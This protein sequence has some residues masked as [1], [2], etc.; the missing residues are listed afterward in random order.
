M[1]MQEQHGRAGLEQNITAVAAGQTAPPALCID[2]LGFSYSGCEPAL[3]D[4][5]L[6]MREGEFLAILGPNGGGKTTL[7]RLI[8]GLLRP[9]LGSVRVFGQTP[10]QVS[11]N[12]G[13]VPQFS[14]LRPDFP[15]SV[16]EMV[17]MGAASPS[18]FGG[19][20]SRSDKAKERAMEYLDVLGLDDCA[21]KRVGTLS[22]GQRQRALVARALMSRPE[23]QNG[24]PSPFLLLLDE[25]TASIDPQGKFCFYEFLGKLRGSITMLVISHDLFMVSP[26]FSSIAF[27]NKQLT[28]FED[29]SLSPENLTLL[30]GQHLHNCPVADMQHARGLLHES[31]CSHPACRHWDENADDG[32]EPSPGLASGS[33][34]A[35]RKKDASTSEATLATKESAWKE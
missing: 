24:A 26:F 27:V 21:D 9:Q 30:F 29:N 35:C 12:I 18:L 23:S 25:P 16:L 1:Y 3:E 15:A 17:L 14:T 32:N 22:G 19:G 20:W 7:L 4:V 2:Q 33:E 6:T 34:C 13:Y 31:G 8:L 28:R 10:S 11:R 5:C